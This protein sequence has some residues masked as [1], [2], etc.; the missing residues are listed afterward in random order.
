M[1]SGKFVVLLRGVNVGKGCRVPMAQFQQ[2][3][4]ELGY[5][6]VVTTFS[7]AAILYSP[8]PPKQLRNLSRQ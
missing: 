2:G 3:L 4:E 8:V 1:T 5:T 7:M 6:E